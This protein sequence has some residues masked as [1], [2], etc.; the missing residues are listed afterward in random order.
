MAGFSIGRVY[1]TTQRWNNVL[2]LR[3]NRECLACC[4][5]GNHLEP[6]TGQPYAVDVVAPQ[7]CKWGSFALSYTLHV[8]SRANRSPILGF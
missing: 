4:V 2:R 7:L 8:L 3:E 1:A 6:T 5:L